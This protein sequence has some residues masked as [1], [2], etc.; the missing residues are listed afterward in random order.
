LSQFPE[1]GAVLEERHDPEIREI[2]YGSYRIIYRFHRPTV[3]VLAV[4]HGA[5]LL[6]EDEFPE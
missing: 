3:F 4:Y 1:L 2:L 6:G 5:R